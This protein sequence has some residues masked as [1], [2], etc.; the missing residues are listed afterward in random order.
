M[1]DHASATAS[2]LA[3]LGTPDAHDLAVEFELYFRLRQ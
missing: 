2:F 1:G 3:G